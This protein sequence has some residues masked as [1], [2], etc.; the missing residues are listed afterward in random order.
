VKQAKQSAGLVLLAATLRLA[1]PIALSV[2]LGSILTSDSHVSYALVELIVRQDQV[3]ALCVTMATLVG[4]GLP[5]ANHVPPEGCSPHTATAPPPTAVK[6]IQ[7]L[8]T[9]SAV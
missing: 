5:Y 1:P 8:S 7:K 4:L 2:P 3:P 9:L 6:V